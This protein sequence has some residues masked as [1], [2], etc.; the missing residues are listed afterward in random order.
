MNV[1]MQCLNYV[2]MWDS[3]V[4][5]NL[6]MVVQSLYYLRMYVPYAL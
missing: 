2:R 4:M 3:R 6:P 1:R 5:F